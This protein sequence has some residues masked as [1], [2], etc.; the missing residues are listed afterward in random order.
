MMTEIVLTLELLNILGVDKK[1]S[2]FN[3]ANK[4][5]FKTPGF[6]E[7]EEVICMCLWDEMFLL[8]PLDLWIISIQLRNLKHLDSFP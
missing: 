5:S 1:S 7:A 3:N 8:D 6:L 4:I 2:V